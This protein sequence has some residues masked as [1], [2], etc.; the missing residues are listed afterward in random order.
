MM[1]GMNDIAAG[2]Y[3]E[4]QGWVGPNDPREPFGECQIELTKLWDKVIANQNLVKA[5]RLKATRLGAERNRQ[6]NAVPDML[7]AINERDYR[8]CVYLSQECGVSIDSETP[9]THVTALI[10]A[11]EEDTG[12]PFY[13]PMLNDD[14]KPCLAVEYLLDRTDF[15]PSVNL[16]VS[17]GHTALI[18]ACS[19][20]RASV[21]E[22]LLDRGAEVNYVNKFGKTP[23]H[24]AATVG[25]FI[26]CRM[27]LGMCS[28][29]QRLE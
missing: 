3:V 10:G 21:L 4:N 26:C 29:M 6:K 23:L 27:L 14:G 11:A 9:N 16:E 12:V 17:S 20:S 22:A 25:S 13:A 8:K 24:Y 2:Q 19:L 1:Q 15:R 28:V 7:K 18:R 5:D